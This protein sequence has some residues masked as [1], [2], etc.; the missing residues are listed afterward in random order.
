MCKWIVDA[1]QIQMRD[2]DN[3]VLYRTDTVDSFVDNDR[4]L[5]IEGPKGLGKTYLMKSK[6]MVSQQAGILCLPQDSMC[7]ILDKVTFED[8]MSKYLQDYTNWVDLWKAAICISVHKA[9]IQ[10]TELEE[11]LINAI[12]EANDESDELYLQIYYNPFLTTTC[13]IMNRLINSERSHVRSMQTRIP[14][15]MAVV[16]KIR[17]P[18]H[19]FIDKTDQALRDNLHYIGGVSKMSRGPS[20]SSYWSYGQLALAEAS[21]QLFIQNPHIKVFYSIRSE[22]L[23]GAESFTNLFVQ[24][25]SYM[26]KL[27]YSFYEMEQMFEHYISIEDDKWLISPESRNADPARAFVGISNIEHGYVTNKSG[28]HKTETLFRY[29]YRHSLKRPRDIM[30]IC[31]RL[32]YSQLKN[33]ENDDARKKEIRHVVNQESRLLLQSYLREMGPFVFDDNEEKWDLFWKMIDT[34]VFTYE[35]AKE[36]CSLVNAS[37]EE[38]ICEKECDNCPEFKPFSALYN[39]GLLGVVSRNNVIDDPTI[40][41]FQSTGQAIIKTNEEIIPHVSLYFLHPM[42]TN[43]VEGIRL[44]RNSNFDICRELIVGDGYEIDEDTIVRIRRREDDR[45]NK[46]RSNSVFL[47]STCF[48]LHDCR[49]M[50]Y[51]ELGR[52]DYHVVMS[53]RNDFGMPLDDINSYDFCL[54]KV[55]ECNQLIYI[56]GER[57]GGPY[58]GKKYAWLADEIKRL[59]PRI[60]E[61]S[62]SMMEFYW[63]KKQGKTTRVFTKKD[64]YNER[65][66]YEKNM[67]N[68]SFKPAFAQS[69]KVFEIISTIT[70]METGNW[71]K[72]YEDLDDLIEIIK[73]EFG[74]RERTI[75]P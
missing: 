67:D 3:R 24:L 7:D 36:L 74:N 44:D 60:S 75:V 25:R 16:K 35:Y 18:V 9:C 73:I 43:K 39:T 13:Q 70:R 29:I 53:E 48:D 28:E 31:Y 32:C 20:N 47:S 22:A 63:A 6:R 4:K 65:S 38:T 42:V 61:P 45:R 71:F 56:I 62:I 51:R 50:I 40:I 69:T 68:T 8:S 10:G 21:Y 52:Y 1:D 5:G 55:S 54:D 17:Q 14:F 30:H 57:Y 34:N 11:T 15:Y 26:V 46:K 33:F 19:I 41:R 27:E 58:R 49:R 23:V 59:N 66:T 12:K 37:T 2:Y 64:I 72:T